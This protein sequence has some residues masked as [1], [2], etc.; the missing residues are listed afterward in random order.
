MIM[1]LA[2]AGFSLVFSVVLRF[3]L[4]FPWD[5]YLFPSL[6]RLPIYNTAESLNKVIRV[7]L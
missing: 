3:F 7:G 1:G 2:L 6:L 5:I 4:P